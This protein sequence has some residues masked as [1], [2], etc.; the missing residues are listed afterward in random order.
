MKYSFPMGHIRLGSFIEGL[1][2]TLNYHHVATNI[3]FHW[4]SALAAKD[5]ICRVSGASCRGSS[6]SSKCSLKR[7]SRVVGLCF[8]GKQFG[9]NLAV[10]CV[11]SLHS[12]PPPTVFQSACIIGASIAFAG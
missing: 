4:K 11:S 8:E 2:F 6:A 3:C 1:A 10:L 5:C 9:E 12:S 7:L